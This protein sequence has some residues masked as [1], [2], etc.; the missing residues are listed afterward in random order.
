MSPTLF[1]H[2]EVW[3]HGIA[4]CRVEGEHVVEVA[5]R[6]RP[7]PGETVVDGNGGSLLPGLADHH[8]H[9]A[10]MASSERSVDLEHTKAAGLREV[11]G[12]ATHGPDGWIRAIGY[13]D[14]VHGELD[15]RALDALRAD[16]PV[17]VQHR[18][19]ALWV[20]NTRGCTELGLSSEA[21]PGVEKDGA[22]QPTG[23]LWRL[24]TWLR[25]KLPP[26]PPSLRQVGR[27]LA[28][29]G[30]THVTDATPGAEAGPFLVAAARR[31]ELPQR[32]LSLGDGLGADT[33]PRVT[34]GPRKIVIADHA[35]P[36]FDDLICTVAD[37][38]SKGRPVAFHCV[39]RASLALVLG[40]LDAAGPRQGDRV[41]HC[42]AADLDTVEG[43]AARGMRV[44]TQPGLVARRGDT[45][46]ERSAPS[47][48]ADLWRYASLLS[49]G[50][51]VAPSSDAPY[52]DPDPWFG[53]HAAATRTTLSGQLVGPAERVT[54]D[55]VLRG[56][57]S[58]SDDPGGPARRIEPGVDADLVLLERP[59]AAALETCSSAAVRATMI[60]GAFVHFR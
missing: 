35:L 2:V 30:I 22:D 5:S 9:L 21:E 49:A 27:K 26:R 39:T 51:A 47:D 36:N 46:W 53:I 42:A 37:S 4:D 54:P 19:G 41:E 7:R 14:A 6:L 58:P 12:R 34:L 16:V 50:V 17:R 44:V 57:L 25:A 59:L 40:A 11:L 23:R 24:D 56:Y 55:T 52:G 20:V 32:V 48:R 15:R 13:D 10:A 45:Y 1:R 31:G 38:H 8:L 60:A 33:H 29:L 28:E 43:L 18:S 3:C